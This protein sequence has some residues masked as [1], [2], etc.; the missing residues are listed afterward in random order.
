MSYL[1]VSGSFK[2]FTENIM[3]R[4]IKNGCVL[5]EK[6]ELFQ[7]IFLVSQIYFKVYIVF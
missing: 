6:S 7:K 4:V 1:S 2:Y 3:Q 5:K